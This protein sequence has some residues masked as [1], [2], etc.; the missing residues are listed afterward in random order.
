VVLKI[1]HLIIFLEFELQSKNSQGDSILERVVFSF[2]EVTLSYIFFKQGQIC[3]HP[4]LQGTFTSSQVS[5]GGSHPDQQFP[6]ILAKTLP[7][8]TMGFGWTATPASLSNRVQ[9]CGNLTRCVCY[10]IFDKIMKGDDTNNKW[11][12]SLRGGE[13][14]DQERGF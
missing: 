9:M 7:P 8:T 2:M 6:S 11:I 10:H 1:F 12:P 14:S 5:L 3:K 13:A 4:Y